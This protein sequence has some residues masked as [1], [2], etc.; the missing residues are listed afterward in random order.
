MSAPKMESLRRE[1]ARSQA[2]QV[3]YRA[4]PWTV[5]ALRQSSPMDGHTLSQGAF[6]DFPE[7]QS[8]R[9]HCWRGSWGIVRSPAGPRVSHIAALLPLA[10]GP[11]DVS[12]QW[13]DT[14]VLT[15][16]LPR[17]WKPHR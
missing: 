16:E 15:R 2:S 17:S 11:G 14:V 10:A 13:M 6:L 12:G 1:F 8:S 9:G 5:G 4:D 7:H 3:S